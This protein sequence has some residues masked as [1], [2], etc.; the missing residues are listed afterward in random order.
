MTRHP[1][2]EAPVKPPLKIPPPL[3]TLVL[4]A[5]GLGTHFAFPQRILPEG[6]IQFA[7]GIPVVALGV[8]LAVSATKAFQRAGTDERFAEPTS[9]IV[10]DGLF[11]RTRNP[12]FLSL[13]MLYVGVV[14]TV[15]A[16]W[17]LVG[18]PLLILYLHFGVVRREET[19]LEDRF[20]EEYL[21]YKRSVPRWIPRLM[22]D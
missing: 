6:G 16:A 13:V 2:T 9:V 14:L 7:F 5:G 8:G 4:L 10:Q 12:M 1:N 11:A 19:Y 15:N 21:R 18:L 22:P 17:A 3:V 20:G